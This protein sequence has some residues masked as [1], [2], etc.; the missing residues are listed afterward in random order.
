M[1][2]SSTSCAALRPL[3]LL[4]SA[5]TDATF[6]DES[7]DIS[8]AGFTAHSAEV[9]P[10]FLFVAI[11]G[12][13]T[14]GHDHIADAV[15]R[16]ARAVVLTDSDR[17]PDDVPVIV[18]R[19]SRRALAELA[20]AWHGHP[21]QRLALV[22]I[23]G[24]VGKTSILVMIERI[25]LAA[26][27]PTASIGSLGVRIDDEVSRT[28][29]TAPDPQ[30]LHA[31]LAKIEAEGGEF[32]VMEA[33]SHAMAQ[34]RIQGLGFGL[35]VFTN[36]IPLEHSD[37][38]GTFR[39]YVKVKSRFFEHLQPEAPVVFNWDDRA[40]RQLV[41]NRDVRPVGCGLSRR[42]SVRIE[43]LRFGAGGTRFTLRVRHPLPRIDGGR[44]DPGSI[45]VE[46]K[47]L[48]RSNVRN[49]ALA[50]TAALCLGVDGATA[51]AA[52]REL[53]PP[54]RRMEIVHDDGF[55]VIDDTVGH[56]DSVSAVFEVAEHLSAKRVHAVV[57]IRGARGTRINRQLALALA[58]WTE[59]IPPDT[60]IVTPATDS[61]DERNRVTPRERET[62]VETLRSAGI[63]FEETETLREATA[64]AAGR[65]RDGDLLL[66]L[67]AQGMDRGA[68]FLRESLRQRQP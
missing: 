37:Y 5:I 10:G 66:L 43:Q 3:S 48:G 39:D 24:T 2:D 21:A 22:G 20:A 60:L 25:L 65:L 49:A 34:Q 4:L 19:D 12:T 44:V 57:A 8:V 35:G 52:I 7:S 61:A 27:R 26:G 1:P 53:K 67:G 56:P 33:T 16:G 47:L 9:Q 31:A 17:A 59:R 63:A 38:H 51:G 18:V 45:E 58:T 50:I 64:R 54:R 23:T 30:V 36:L 14:D 55:L 62:F 68:E 13:R 6:V 32:V 29:F 42:A 15:A 41:K 46:T 11:R 28:G 40:V